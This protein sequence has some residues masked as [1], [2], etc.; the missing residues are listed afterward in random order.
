MQENKS[1]PGIQKLNRTTL[2]AV[3]NGPRIEKAWRASPKRG[4]R[5]VR[6]GALQRGSSGASL[7][8]FSRRS[9]SASAF[10][11][12]CLCPAASLVMSAAVSS[13]PAAAAVAAVASL[14]SAVSPVPSAGPTVH[15]FSVPWMD[16]FIVRPQP[17]QRSLQSRDSNGARE[18]HTHSLSLCMPFVLPCRS[19]P[20]S[21]ARSTVAAV[22]FRVRV[23]GRFELQLPSTQLRDAVAMGPRSKRQL[24]V[25]SRGQPSRSLWRKR[26]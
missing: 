14:S 3:A 24:S 5:G 20:P 4:T 8:L 13:P 10:S 17:L 26:L 1:N 16:T 11:P 2:I 6:S 19:L 22:V 25:G 15:N 18:D 23:A 21:A 7:A 9:V 12:L